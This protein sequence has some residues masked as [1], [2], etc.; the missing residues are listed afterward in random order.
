MAEKE[1]KLYSCEYIMDTAMTRNKF[2]VDKMLYSGLYIL[3]GA[4]KVGKSWLAL[5]LCISLA[6]GK[7][8][9][10][11]ETNK[12]ETLYLALE[13]SLLRLQNRVYEFTDWRQG[14]RTALQ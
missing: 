1:L 8:F 3:A 12:G 5:D 4:P 11:H 10:K 7:Q 14:T 9:L 6:S 13:D 2:I